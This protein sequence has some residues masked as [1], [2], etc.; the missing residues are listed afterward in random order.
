MT[1]GTAP[2]II[3]PYRNADCSS[4]SSTTW[5]STVVGREEQP[6]YKLLIESTCD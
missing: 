1:A 2:T 4:F 5:V 6:I 3:T